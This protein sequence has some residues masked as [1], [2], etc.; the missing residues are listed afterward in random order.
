MGAGTL[1]SAGFA[2]ALLS[3]IVVA[4]REPFDDGPVPMRSPVAILVLA[5]AVIGGVLAAHN[6][7]PV[8]LA[9]AAIVCLALV[10]CWCSDATVGI[11]PDAFT[12]PPLLI[13][14]LFAI[15]DRQ[16]WIIASSIITAVPFAAAAAF[17]KGHGLGWGDVKLA[18]L[19]GAVLGAQVSVLVFAVASLAAVIVSRFRGV[20]KNE[21]IAFAP[22][23][24]AAIGV[25]IPIGSLT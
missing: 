22:Y 12:I 3:R 7:S 2:G 4:D 9:L 23:L 17:T 5:C 10:A 20:D 25:A 16:W 19:G 21:P 18:A 6:V 1:A 13:I 11:V 15:V 14:L 24:A 8:Q